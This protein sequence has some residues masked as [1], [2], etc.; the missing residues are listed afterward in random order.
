M[1]SDTPNSDNTNGDYD[2]NDNYLE[3]NDEDFNYDNDNIYNVDNTFIVSDLE[4][5]EVDKLT[6]Q[7]NEFFIPL[8]DFIEVLKED[9][10]LKEYFKERNEIINKIKQ[11]FT[12]LCEDN[13]YVIE[14]SLFLKG[15]KQVI[16]ESIEDKE[17]KLLEQKSN[18][19][20]DR[21]ENKLR[22]YEVKLQIYE[23]QKKNNTAS[24]SVLNKLKEDLEHYEKKIFV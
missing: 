6:K 16:I 15:L 24:P 7:M 3:I 12:L 10:S 9:C 21:Y 4:E 17:I 2:E 1:D 23:R 20:L 18:V 22:N 14:N 13:Q 5:F 19:V 8:N 11:N